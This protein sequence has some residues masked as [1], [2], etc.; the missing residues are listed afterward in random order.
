MLET[1]QKIIKEIDPLLDAGDLESPGKLLVDVGRTSLRAVLIHIQ[2]ERGGDVA[3]AV[4]SA[5]LR[6]QDTCVREIEVA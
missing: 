4:G 3:D 1:T 6:E 5:F 2:R